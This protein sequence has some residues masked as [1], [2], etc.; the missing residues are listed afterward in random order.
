MSEQKWTLDE[1]SELDGSYWILRGHP[2]LQINM[3]TNLADARAIVAKLNAEL[4]TISAEVRE[5]C[6]VEFIKAENED[7]G[8]SEEFIVIDAVL[9]VLVNRGIIQETKPCE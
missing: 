1:V 5:E 3:M 8:F 2:K 4:P 7:D 9:R 6:K